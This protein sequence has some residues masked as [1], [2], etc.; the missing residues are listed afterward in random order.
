MPTPQTDHPS[1]Y[2]LLPS[3]S[4]HSS[5][6]NPLPALPTGLIHHPLPD[7][8][9]LISQ[10]T[11]SQTKPTMMNC[12]KKNRTLEEQICLLTLLFLPQ[13]NPIPSQT[14]ISTDPISFPK[15]LH[16]LT[17]PL[18]SLHLLK[19]HLLHQHALFLPYYLPTL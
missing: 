17:Y 15:P 14:P 7:T 3:P 1:T 13:I 18:R 12:L 11:K 6:S 5:H 4:H 9:T 8:L 16:P 2:Q 19:S 10:N